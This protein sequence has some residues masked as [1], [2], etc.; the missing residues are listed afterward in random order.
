MPLTNEALD[1]FCAQEM[2]SLTSCDAPDLSGAFDQASH[3]IS[4]LV[5]SSILRI[6]IKDEVRPYLFGILRRAQMT[7]VEYQNGRL[8]LL[9]FV[10]GSKDRVSVYFRAL[11]QFEITV[12]LLYQAHELIIQLT[13]KPLFSKNDGS[14]I[15]RLNRIYNVSKHLEA[16]TITP[17]H[18]H[19]VWITNTGLSTSTSSITWHE[20][21]DLIVD[22]GKIAD[23][24]SNPPEPNNSL[25]ADRER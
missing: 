21:A 24:V 18:I 13:K 11:Y 3:W 10:A 7:I 5:L 1:M 16:S 8:S 9:D 14:P 19:P 12:S 22:I 20:L 4:N 17:G 2:S 25:Q 23:V 6:R 15:E